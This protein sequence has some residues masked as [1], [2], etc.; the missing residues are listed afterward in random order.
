MI[1]VITPG[2]HEL[3]HRNKLSKI[4]FKKSERLIEIEQ[5]THAPNANTIMATAVRSISI[6][7]ACSWWN[8]IRL[9]MCSLLGWVPVVPCTYPT[10]NNSE[11]T[12]YWFPLE[13]YILMGMWFRSMACIDGSGGIDWRQRPPSSSFIY[14]ECER[15][16]IQIS[17]NVSQ[18]QLH[19]K[20]D[21]R[22]CLSDVMITEVASGG[23]EISA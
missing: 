17:I 2:H 12:C 14:R 9:W 20:C 4:G 11:I 15:K 7:Y 6:G 10:N 23:V 18:D 22:C 3:F 13:W 16:R 5:R 21:V 1:L 8:T 19:V